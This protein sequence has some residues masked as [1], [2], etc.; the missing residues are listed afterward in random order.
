MNILP[1]EG[2]KTWNVEEAISAIFDLLGGALASKSGRVDVMEIL[3]QDQEPSAS[4]HRGSDTGQTA[5]RDA[6][7][8]VYDANEYEQRMSDR[9]ATAYDA[10]DYDKAYADALVVDHKAG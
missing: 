3:T 2:V 7:G 9:W 4:S 6:A 5:Y 8:P 10:H 1:N